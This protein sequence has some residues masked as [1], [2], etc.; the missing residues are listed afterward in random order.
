MEYKY[1]KYRSTVFFFSIPN[2]KLVAEMYF[3]AGYSQILFIFFFF[4]APPLIGS[5]RGVTR[6]NIL[7]N[8]S[9]KNDFLT[10]LPRKKTA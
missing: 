9:D 6:N 4:T 2:V 8:D 5:A 3:D 1:Y 7:I 10:Y